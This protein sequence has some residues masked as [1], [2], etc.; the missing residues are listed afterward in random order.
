MFQVQKAKP[1][2][3]STDPWDWGWE[4]NSAQQDDWNNGWN[5]APTPNPPNVI[6][7]PHFYPS[8][9]EKNAHGTPDLIP[10]K[11]NNMPRGNMMHIG[12]QQP[13]NQVSNASDFFENID[14]GRQGPQTAPVTPIYRPPQPSLP[15]SYSMFQPLPPQS[16]TINRHA[17]PANYFH[18]PNSPHS[19]N[20]EP[21]VYY[22]QPPQ[23]HNTGQTFQNS[24][25]YQTEPNNQMLTQDYS[26]NYFHKN[27]PTVTSNNFYEQNSFNNVSYQSSP[28]VNPVEVENI[29]VPVAPSEPPIPPAVN[30][31]PLRINAP[32]NLQEIHQ[33]N[34][35]V[36]AD[37]TNIPDNQETV[38]DD[39][40]LQ[41]LPKKLG[42]MKISASYNLETVS[43]FY[44]YILI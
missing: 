24:Q 13:F 6:P 40:H 21:P 32:Q 41:N 4:D 29:E 26:N 18:Q 12:Q 10:D 7:A 31:D 33:T 2:R 39:E 8:K 27:Q 20:N 3:Q 16:S 14:L 23:A 5:Q 11:I 37:E 22:Q 35:L 30:S 19:A 9:P 44:Y 17:T 42:Q 36:I 1:G 34:S 25:Y 38:T 28:S 43:G 15:P